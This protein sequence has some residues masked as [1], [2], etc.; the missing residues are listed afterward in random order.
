MF[1]KL[2]VPGGHTL[3]LVRHIA[4]A[5]GVGRFFGHF[6]SLP[7]LIFFFSVGDGPI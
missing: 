3:Y 5:A 6:A 7:F 4:L 1:G 2:S